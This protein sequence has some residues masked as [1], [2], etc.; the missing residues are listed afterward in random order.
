MVLLYVSTV[1][2]Q[3]VGSVQILGTESIEGRLVLGPFFPDDPETDL[4]AHVG[5]EVNIDPGEGD[6]VTTSDG[7]ILIWKQYADSG[8]FVTLQD[9]LGKHRSATGYVFC[10]L[11]SDV[12]GNAQIFFGNSGPVVVWVNG[13]RV[14]SN[15]RGISHA[16][17]TFAVNLK[18]GANRCLVKLSSGLNAWTVAT[19]GR[20]RAD[21]R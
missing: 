8:V 5:G 1:R 18:A 10:L 17:S 13:E 7:T 16:S 3:D 2:A 12:A 15:H 4:L 19:W 9:T 14:H 11:K 20:I 6:T 21:N